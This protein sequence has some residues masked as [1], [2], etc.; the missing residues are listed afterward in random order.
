MES[1]RLNNWLTQ[2]GNIGVLAGLAVLII[3]IRQNNELTMAQIEQS[4]SEAFLGWRQE[5]VLS[6]HIAPLIA[7]VEQI[8]KDMYGESLRRGGVPHH[9]E[10][11]EIQKR[12]A[13]IIDKLEVDD[14]VRYEAFI[15]RNYWDFENLHAS[16]FDAINGSGSYP[17]PSNRHRQQQVLLRFCRRP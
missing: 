2:L 17:K 16:I 15:L 10:N 1:G 12:V 9:A 14:R 6:D 8:S 11:A 7:K 4:R 3:E 13:G 5:E